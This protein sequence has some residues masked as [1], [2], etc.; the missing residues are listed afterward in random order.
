M[1]GAAAGGAGSVSSNTCYIESAA[2]VGEGARTGLASV[3]TGIGFLLAVFL[4][5]IVR[6]VPSEAAAPVLFFVGYLMIMQV[7]EV[8]WTDLENGIPAFVTIVMMPFAYSITA[9]IGAG[10]L[11]YVAIKVFR[12]KIR[13][14]HPLMAV[15]A[16]MFLLYFAQG[17]ILR[18][19]G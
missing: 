12:G 16:V 17:L 7:V 19:V 10:F 5:P 11:L 4:A 18:S 3:V 1:A 2:G 15:V 8:D 9:G 6:L 13:Q 14:I